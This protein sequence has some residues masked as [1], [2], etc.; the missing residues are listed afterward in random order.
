MTKDASRGPLEDSNGV[1]RSFWVCSL[2]MAEGCLVNWETYELDLALSVFLYLECEG[3]IQ[4][5]LRI[6]DKKECLMRP[7]GFVVLFGC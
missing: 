2:L 5:A 4:F 7:F 1:G 3:C 6:F